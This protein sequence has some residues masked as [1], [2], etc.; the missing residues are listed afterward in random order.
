M[1]E[2]YMFLFSTQRSTARFRPGLTNTDAALER[3]L[4]K[5]SFLLEYPLPNGL[6][7]QQNDS[8]SGST[9]PVTLPTKVHPV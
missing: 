9:W 4:K 8:Y 7:Q 1:T 2:K 6:C 3:K 5:S